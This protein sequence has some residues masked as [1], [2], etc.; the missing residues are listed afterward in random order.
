MKFGI[1]LPLKA[2]HEELQAELSALTK[3]P[4]RVG[5]A[6]REVAIALQPH[7]AKEEKFALPPLS[8]LPAVSGGNVTAEMAAVTAMTDNLR[9]ELPAMLREHKQIA[10]AVQ[11]LLET[12]Q[13][14][15][16]A[17]ALHFGQKLLAH[18]QAEELVMY[19]AAILLGDWVRHRLQQVKHAL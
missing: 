1:P 12:A 14:A 7:F 18:A 9:A 8:L 16:D 15:G 5:A 11:V 17:P 2:E 6:A 13:Q 4:G 19:P 3:S 10:S